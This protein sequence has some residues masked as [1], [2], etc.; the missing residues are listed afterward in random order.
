[1]IGP[2]EAAALAVDDALDARPLDRTDVPEMLALVE[3]TRPGPFFE[4][5]IELGGYVGVRRGGALVA[6]AGERMRP[7]GYAEISAVCT[8][9]AYRAQGLGAGLVKFVARSIGARGETPMLHVIEDNVSAI[10]VYE[11]VGFTT[12]T[13]IDVVGARAP[14]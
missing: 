13:V 8:D 4:R 7:P 12:R 1:M 6:M 5:T 2:A 14:L 11:R 9:P 3:R 10:R